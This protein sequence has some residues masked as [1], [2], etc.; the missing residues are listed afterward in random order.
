MCTL[1]VALLERADFRIRGHVEKAGLAGL[2]TIQAPAVICLCGAA[3]FQS[4][5]L[6]KNSIDIRIK[7]LLFP[8]ALRR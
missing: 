8:E 4:S 2:M 6:A 3:A 5:L 1:W 7:N